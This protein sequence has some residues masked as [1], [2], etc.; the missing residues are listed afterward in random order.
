MSPALFVQYLSGL[1]GGV[2]NKAVE[3]ESE[4][5]SFADDVVWVV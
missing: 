1:S 2:E 3:C 4:A 5:I